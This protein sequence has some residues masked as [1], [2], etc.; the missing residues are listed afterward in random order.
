MVCTYLIAA[1]LT[2]LIVPGAAI[3]TGVLVDGIGRVS[4]L[5]AAVIPY[6]MGWV[7]IA[8]ATD[9][10]FIMIGRVLTGFALGKLTLKYYEITNSSTGCVIRATSAR[11]QQCERKCLI[12]KSDRRLIFI[13]LAMGSSP[14]A[15][16]ITEV[17][18]PDLRGALICLG[19]SMTSLG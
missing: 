19:P 12:A 4:T 17:A 14:A 7:L 13:L 1:S 11:I 8:I 6:V 15:V 3:L 2:V 18:R 5:R 10:T 16:Y 9:L